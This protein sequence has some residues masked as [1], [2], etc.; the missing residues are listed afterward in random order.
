MASALTVEKYEEMWKA[1]CERQSVSHVAKA[2]SVAYATARRYIRKG[3]PARSLQPFERRWKLAAH[4][5]DQRAVYD[6]ARAQSETLDITAAI[7]EVAA[8]QIAKLKRDKNGEFRDP[9]RAVETAHK[10]EALILGGSTE[11]VTLSGEVITDD[12]FAGMDAQEVMEF[13]EEGVAALK[14]YGFGIE[15]DGLSMTDGI[16]DETAVLH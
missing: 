3:D 14:R 12:P 6:L 11:N 10:V 2:C 9:V 7:K 8:R 13:L 5:S 16:A 4:N 1:Y 15:G